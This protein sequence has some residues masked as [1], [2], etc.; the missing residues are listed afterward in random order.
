MPL[1]KCGN[2]CYVNLLFTGN[3]YSFYGD[4]HLD[5]MR[6]CRGY[7]VCGGGVTPLN[8][9]ITNRKPIVM[10]IIER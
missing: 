9:I 1:D 5:S 3:S 4:F 8:A 2:L 6:Y 7:A 10:G